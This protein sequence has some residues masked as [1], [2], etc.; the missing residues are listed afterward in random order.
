M[1]HIYFSEK[2][3]QRIYRY[4]DTYRAAYL[5]LYD[6]TWLWEAETIIKQWYIQNADIL[7]ESLYAVIVKRLEQDTVLGYSLDPNGDLYYVTARLWSRRVYLTYTE[8]R[9]NQQRVVKDI[10]IWRK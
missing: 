9:E 10:E 3:E 6:D 7:E 8:D 5:T 2:A 1:I 4:I